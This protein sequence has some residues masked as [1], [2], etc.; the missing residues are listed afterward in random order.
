MRHAI[1]VAHRSH[2]GAGQD[3]RDRATL[4]EHDPHDPGEELGRPRAD[5]ELAP[6]PFGEHVRPTRAGPQPDQAPQ[7]P[8]VDEQNERVR[9]A[10]DRRDEIP[11]HDVLR[12]VVP[13]IAADHRT[14][15][16]P[17]EE[18]GDDL[19]GRKREND[20]DGRGEHRP[21]TERGRGDGEADREGVDDREQRLRDADGRHG[22]QKDQSAH[23][24]HEATSR[25]GRSSPTTAAGGGLGCWLTRGRY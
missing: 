3:R 1:L 21:E 23:P 12:Q 10:P 6:G 13:P 19:A 16:D 17:N 4:V 18:R 9:L 2:R 14:E 20:G 11:L 24:E 15:R 8:Q 22:G 5:D 7:R 25:H